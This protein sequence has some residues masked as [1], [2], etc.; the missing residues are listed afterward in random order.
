M[1]TPVDFF[2]E[3]LIRHTQV[4]SKRIKFY[5]K[6]VGERNIDLL[7]HLPSHLVQRISIEKISEARTGELVTLE[8][9]VQIHYPN[10]RKSTPYRIL[11]HDKT[12]TSIELTF[13]NPYSHFLQRSAPEGK[14]ILISG[15]IKQAQQS[16]LAKY[17]MSHPDFMGPVAEKDK[18]VGFERIY[19]LTA[20]LNRS[21]IAA[22]IHKLI[23]S[24]PK[25]PEWQNA[26][27]NL[28]SFV[29]SLKSIHLGS[30][31][32]VAYNSE[33]RKRLILD[34][35]M[36]YHI[37]LA[38]SSIQQEPL[39]AVQEKFVISK[40]SQSVEK[41]LPFTLTKGQQHALTDIRH[42][43]HHLKQMVK[44]VQGDVG[45]GKTVVALLAC[46]DMIAQG[47]QTAILV[48]TE[49]LAQQHFQKLQEMLNPFNIHVQLLTGRGKSK[50]R[51]LLLADLA[52][53]KVQLLVGTHAL[54]EQ[55]VRFKNLKLVVIDEQHRFGV[56]QRLKLCS[57]GNN[58]HILSMTATP[59]PRTMVLAKH[60]D[61]TITQIREKP[62]GR[63]NIITKVSTEDR[64]DDI[65]LQL[66]KVMKMGR[67]IYWVCPMIEESEK[68]DLTAA[69]VRF[70]K[71]QQKFGDT[72]ALVHGKMKNDEK[73]KIMK[74]FSLGEKKLL[75]S[76]TVIEVGVD[77]ANATVMIIEQA[78]RFGLAQLHQLRGRV[79]RSDI[80]SYC[81]LLY[82]QPLSLH[83]KR[84]L[85]IMR[86]T[87]DGF[88]I[89]EQD[90]KL[91]GGGE[92][93]GKRQ[94]GLP[95]FRFSDLS[96]EDP[97]IAKYHQELFE[98]AYDYAHEILKTNPNLIGEQGNAIK[99]LLELFE[100]QNAMNLRKSG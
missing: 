71:L 10:I 24:S 18:W 34:E 6:L 42:D 29:N 25:L 64:L 97:E 89:A 13:F 41:N 16:T 28:P 7:W 46:C 22:L 74:A 72:V 79:G 75:V 68:I 2:F 39:K 84:R 45:S 91:R 61:M 59:I 67:Q 23:G 69:T 57:K 81:L 99:I 96:D 94:S 20:G 78:Q 5:K 9:D 85:E 40:L 66:E 90:L 33:E 8:V 83:G 80:Q 98:K 49:I 43:L 3:P 92:I 88:L 14:K 26:A 37:S 65:Y 47:F 17:Q 76:T 15:Q 38:L 52:N 4:G 21:M 62:K 11:V 73:E 48:P 44:L 70:E 58:P 12:H 60:G 30:P 82:S 56:E 86:D 100:K 32:A 36:A 55:D 87:N 63:K 53:G 35:Y 54:I 77:V 1:P 95:K 31:E 19:P 93:V 51:E 50:S 27:W